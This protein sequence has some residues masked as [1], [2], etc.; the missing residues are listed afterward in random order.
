MLVSVINLYVFSGVHAL[1]EADKAYK[2]E[3]AAYQSI[4]KTIGLN[5]Q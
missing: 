2:D 1:S 3:T 5:P 4:A